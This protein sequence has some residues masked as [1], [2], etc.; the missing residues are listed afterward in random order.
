MTEIIEI[1]SDHI[2]LDDELAIIAKAIAHVCIKL[3]SDPNLPCSIIQQLMRLT[4][5]FEGLMK[6]VEKYDATRK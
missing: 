1:N 5:C 2:N 3:D 6:Q 4:D